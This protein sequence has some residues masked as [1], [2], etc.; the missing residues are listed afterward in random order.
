MSTL[1]PVIQ[2]TP[3]RC[4]SC[5]KFVAKDAAPDVWSVDVHP[6]YQQ[7]P[8]QPNIWARTHCPTCQYVPEGGLSFARK[9]PWRAAEERAA[10]VGR[11][12]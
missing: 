3:G 5:G 7:V 4:S 2:L 10:L 11:A 9:V 6:E 8:G 1:S 12:S